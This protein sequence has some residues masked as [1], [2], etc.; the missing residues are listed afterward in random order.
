MALNSDAKFKEELK[1]CCIDDNEEFGQF[2]QFFLK[3]LKIGTLMGS[4]CLQ[5]IMYE[6][7]ITKELCATTLKNDAKFEK[8]LT[9]H[10]KMISGIL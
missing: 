10:L 1:C 9:C 7:K 6:P 8:E 3:S 5:Y 2:S 4:F